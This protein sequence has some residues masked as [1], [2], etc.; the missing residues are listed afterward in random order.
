MTGNITA[1]MTNDLSVH[2]FSEIS[3]GNYCEK[4]A[5]HFHGG[6]K[7]F[8]LI[9]NFDHCDSE[10]IVGQNFCNVF[11]CQKPKIVIFNLFIRVL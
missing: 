4:S 11:L 7:Q 3:E 10:K 9:T 1:R 2:Y 5:L 6:R 8:F